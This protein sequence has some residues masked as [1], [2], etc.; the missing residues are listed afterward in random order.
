MLNRR[1]TA[2][3]LTTCSGLP[4]L[5]TASAARPEIALVRVG[6]ATRAGAP[7]WPPR[8]V[9]TSPLDTCPPVTAPA[10]RAFRPGQHAGTCC[11]AYSGLVHIALCA[12]VSN[13]FPRLVVCCSQNANH[14][15]FFSK[16]F[17]RIAW[18]TPTLLSLL[19]VCRALPVLPVLLLSLA[20][21]LKLTQGDRKE[22]AHDTAGETASCNLHAAD[23]CSAARSRHTPSARRIPSTASTCGLGAPKPVH[24]CGASER[25]SLFGP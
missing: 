22:Q 20:D 5:G 17:W 6:Q 1:G 15:S 19:P 23:L 24:V 2:G 25:H 3:P 8:H 11:G 13:R 12:G 10:W 18:I 16:A 21:F 14:R 7:G 9:T 4:Q